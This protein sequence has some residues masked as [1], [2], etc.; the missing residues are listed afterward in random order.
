[1][2]IT[3]GPLAAKLNE[4]TEQNLPELLVSTL[5]AKWLRFPKSVSFKV[6]MVKCRTLYVLGAVTLPVHSP[7]YK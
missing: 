4:Q 7:A 2:K 1:M 6:S 3:L 5:I